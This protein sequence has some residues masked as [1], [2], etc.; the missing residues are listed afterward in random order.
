MH[1][2]GIEFQRLSLWYLVLDI[3]VYYAVGL[4]STQ[5]AL[6]LI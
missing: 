6:R 5:N 2:V 4:Y 1:V 3:L